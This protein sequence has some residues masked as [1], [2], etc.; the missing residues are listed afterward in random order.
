LFSAFSSEALTTRTTNVINGSAPYLTFDGGVTKVTDTEGLLG[1][2]I[3]GIGRVTRSSHPSSL[4][5]PIEMVNDGVRF[6]DIDM[7]VP[8]G[9]NTV[10]LN[11]LIS[12]GYWGDD[13]G[14]GQGSGGITA[15]GQLTLTITDKDNQP[16]TRGETLTTCK[17]P[18]TLT[19]ASTGGT[20]R[21]RYGVPRSSTFDGGTATYYLKPK[22]SPA[23]C[24]AK[25][26][27]Y[28]AR[29]NY[30][31]PPTIWNPNKGFLT[32][33]T[34]PAHYDKN[35]PTTTGANGLYFDLDIVGVDARTLSWPNV[36]PH[37]DGITVELRATSA[38]TVRAKLVGPYATSSQMSTDS[39]SPIAVPNLSSSFEIVGRDRSSGNKVITYGFKLKQWFVKRSSRINN[40]AI[41]NSWCSAINYQMPR[42]RDL[43]NSNLYNL[44]ATPP[45][46]NNNYMRYIGA[47]FFT[48][49][50]YMSRYIGVG[51][52]DASYW[53]SDVDV[54]RNVPLHVYAGDGNALPENPNDYLY[55][56]CTSTLP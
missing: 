23:V 10:S 28:Y 40:Y 19:L 5:N 8:L 44:G 49:W 9:S 36:T 24:F 39:P 11:S 41:Q 31:G 20:L 50:G 32:Q 17:S 45:S 4:A 12:L 38:T 35:F 46:S 15:T 25:P 22:A 27:M 14:D 13:D 55:V 52:S 48:E 7:F 42:V 29:G 16:V 30:A 51:F 43:T 56:V 2:T 3:P 26:D 53:T 47:G 37:P 34:D 6:S 21:T 1:I 54:L 33:S 18:Y